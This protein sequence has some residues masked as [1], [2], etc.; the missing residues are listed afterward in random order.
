MR[1]EQHPV[2]DTALG[3]KVT[4][5]AKE[6]L[7]NM[8]AA[9]VRRGCK[10]TEQMIVDLLIMQADVDA[11]EQSLPQKRRAASAVRGERGATPR[12]LER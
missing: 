8:K 6:R 4:A 1:P 11:L 12:F 2:F 5:V 10:A 9:L 7:A 3:V